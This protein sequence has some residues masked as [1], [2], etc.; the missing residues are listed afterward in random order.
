M[1]ILFCNYEYP[2]LG[3]GGGVSNALLA[4]EMA[5]Q[6]EV[7][8]LT[9]L[10]AG[11]PSEDVDAGVKIVR[12]PVFFRRPVANAN[13]RSML[14]FIIMGIKVGRQLLKSQPFDLVNTH[15]VLPSG[16]V[17]DALARA[18]G[19]PNVLTLHGGDLYDP[20]K[21]ASPHRHFILRAW[22]RWLLRRSDLVVGQSTNTLDNMR[23]FYTPE[24]DGVRIPLGIAKPP[25]YAARRQ[26]YGFAADEL[27]CVT[28]GRL[29]ARKGIHQ[30]L[31]VMEA[32]RTE[33]VRLLVLGTGPQAS[34]LQA[35]VRQ[36]GLEAHV[37]FMGH[38]EDS[39]KFGLLQMCDLYVSTSQHEGFGLVFLEAMACGLP[40]VCYGH[41]GQSDFLEDRL[42]G[43]VVPLND[44]V[45]FVEA[46]RTLIRDRAL[47]HRI[48][49]ENAR[50]VEAFF[51]DR[52]AERYEAI[53]KEAMAR[54]HMQAIV[55]LSA[56]KK[57]PLGV[58][59]ARLA[60]AGKEEGLVSA[61]EHSPWC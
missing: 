2:P 28:V 24:I 55:N 54:W 22:I 42:T 7:T 41:G 18:A 27:L 13:F 23:R 29:V 47:R 19:I 37:H 59:E 50:R 36:R 52:C 57:L 56:A 40:I 60:A 25:V 4:R 30:L 21:L 12:V 46:C 38:V 39:A 15:F 14:A 32:L 48:G 43:Y 17:G 35:E 3:G 20:S 49:Q 6:H 53:F 31:A 26:S 5:K 58:A 1:R 9:T 61:L 8:V 34:R 45:G 44:L 10:G 33:R 11:L 51:I 16:P